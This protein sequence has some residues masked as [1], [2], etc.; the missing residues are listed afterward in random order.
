MLD[1]NPSGN[2]EIG[3]LEEVIVDADNE[4]VDPATLALQVVRDIS[5]CVD[6]AASLIK[7]LF[8]QAT[9]SCEILEYTARMPGIE[10]NNLIHIMCFC[11]FYIK[12][13]QY[14][15]NQF[16]KYAYEIAYV[17]DFPVLDKTVL[18]TFAGI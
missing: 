1:L 16:S 11:F 18:E 10:L 2:T 15:F 3:S 4:T 7:K 8:V 5:N 13:T 6:K 17:S 12:K 9:Y 14:T